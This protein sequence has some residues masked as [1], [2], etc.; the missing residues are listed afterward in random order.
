M[1]LD[2]TWLC[3]LWFEANQRAHTPSDSRRRLPSKKA[4]LMLSGLSIFY[5]STESRILCEIYQVL[6]WQLVCGVAFFKCLMAIENMSA[7]RL[8]LLRITTNSS[9]PPKQPQWIFDISLLSWIKTTSS[10]K[11]NVPMEIKSHK[12]L[13]TVAW[14]YTNPWKLT[15]A[16][17]HPQVKIPFFFSRILNLVKTI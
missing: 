15:H 2:N 7:D 4:R 14:S 16:H 11:E 13:P 8:H 1:P 6:S 10:L 3:L 5:L 17:P 12:S 9:H